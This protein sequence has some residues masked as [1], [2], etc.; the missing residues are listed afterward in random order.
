MAEPILVFEGEVNGQVKRSQL[1]QLGKF[2]GVLPFMELFNLITTN[3]VIELV[4]WIQLFKMLDRM[5]REIN[6]RIFFYFV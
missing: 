1:N 5:N 4:V 2:V 6:H 3:E